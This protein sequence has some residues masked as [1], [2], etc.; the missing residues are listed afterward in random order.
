MSI[1]DVC[2]WSHD[3]QSAMCVQQGRTMVTPGSAE[4]Y[5]AIK[6]RHWSASHASNS[7]MSGIR[8]SSARVIWATQKAASS[9]FIWRH[10]AAKV[11]G[12]LRG[13]AV[14]LTCPAA[15]LRP[16]GLAVKRPQEKNCGWNTLVCLCLVCL[17]GR[18]A[19]T[20]ALCQPGPVKPLNKSYS[21]L[22][23]YM[24][25]GGHSSSWVVL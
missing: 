14:L 17:L 2:F 6:L 16:S 3:S 8:I 1:G 10:N 4:A 11:T 23:L 21:S 24:P 13:G 12:L 25:N 7:T 18:G 5:L 9:S 15:P 19:L 20:L 22:V